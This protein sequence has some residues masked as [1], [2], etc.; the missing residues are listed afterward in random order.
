MS[1]R[2][3]NTCS[4]KTP[5]THSSENWINDAERAEMSGYVRGHWECENK[6]HWRLDVIFRE[7]EYRQNTGAMTIALIKRFCMNLLTTKDQ[8]KRRMKHKVMAAAIDDEY[9]AS[10]LFGG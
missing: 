1:P 4:E 6:L 10:V 2:T 7:D 3:P 9:R 5:C 8:S